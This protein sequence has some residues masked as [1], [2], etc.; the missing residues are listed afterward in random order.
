MIIHTYYSSIDD[1]KKATTIRLFKNGQ[2]LPTIAT[3][4]MSLG[5]D[6][7]DIEQVIQWGI[8]EWLTLDTL[9]QHI[10]RAARK[11]SLLG[12]A[13]I[14][15]PHDLLDPVTVKCIKTMNVPQMA[16]QMEDIPLNPVPDEEWEDIIDAV[17]WY[18]DHDLCD[19][20]LPVEQEAS[21]RSN[22]WG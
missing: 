16:S 14:Y 15:T 1:E 9:V 12:L 21:W 17:P 18:A 5:V 11:S 2:V 13:I 20:A 19:F 8:T 10:S 3:N 22:N 4:M 6:I 7:S